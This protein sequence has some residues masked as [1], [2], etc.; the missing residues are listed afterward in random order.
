V[1]RVRLDDLMQPTDLAD[2]PPI[3]VAEIQDAR[4]FRH[5]FPQF[6]T[7]RKMFGSC[8]IF[9]RMRYATCLIAWFCWFSGEMSTIFAQDD[10]WLSPSAIE[11][12]IE[13]SFADPPESKRIIPDGR[14]WIQ[15]DEQ[16]VIVDGYICQRNAPLEMFACP[17]QTKEHEAI[18][19]V[20]AKSQHVHAA[21]LA[22]GAVSGK[23]VSFEPKFTPA[24]GTTVRVF[25]LWHDADGKTQG[26]VAQ[27]WVRQAGKNTPMQ[28]D[29]V[30]A[31]SKFVKDPDTGKE[32]YL[33][34]SGDLICVAN[35]MTST[36]DV[37]VKSNADNTGLVFDAFTERIPKRQTPV[38]LVLTLSPD[39]PFG[40]DASDSAP[41]D[42]NA[43][44]KHLTDPVP[45]S[46]LHF[47]PAR[48]EK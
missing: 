11:E 7:R 16:A 23:P 47:L 25:A 9:F 13:K 43:Q 46:I 29:W 48:K 3:V 12:Q 38:R 41:N 17:I 40:R 26:S 14:V 20:Y 22:V 28:W 36:L 42:S 18:V 5:N 27:N 21:L 2:A 1:N 44:P 19:A 8:K 35:F 34:D 15:R 30:F 39:P 24:S 31:G 37:A 6:F 4:M 33:G 10:A 45:E 32:F